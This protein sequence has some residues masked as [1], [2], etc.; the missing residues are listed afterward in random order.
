MNHGG[1]IGGMKTELKLR[2]ENAINKTI[3]EAADKNLWD[4][5]IHDGLVNQMTNAAEQVFDSAMES[6]LFVNANT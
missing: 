6:Q 4:G 1:R 2:I 3:E 5:Y